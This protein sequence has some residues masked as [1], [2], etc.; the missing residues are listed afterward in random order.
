MKNRDEMNRLIRDCQKGKIDLIITKSVS[1]FARNTQE[2]LMSIRLLKELGVRVYFEEQGI[3]TDKM[4]ME[5]ILAFPGL[6]AQQES[7]SISD[8][9]RWSYKKRMKS[10]DFN[11]CKCAYGFDMKD[12]KLII[13][14]K[15][16]EVV[17]RIFTLYVNGMGKQA[18]AT[19]LNNEKVPLRYG[20]NKWHMGTIS[21]ILTNERYI[22]DALLQKKYTTDT[23][24]FKK[25][26]NKGEQ[27]Q[28]YVENSNPPII[29]KDLYYAVQELIKIK[30]FN[31]EKNK[32]YLLSGKIYF[33]ECGHSY[34]R[35]EIRG[36]IYWTCSYKSSGRTNCNNS[37]I[38]E[39]DVINAYLKMMS[40]LS[41][42]SK[43]IIDP[44]IKQLEKLQRKTSGSS[45][46]V[47]EIDERIANFS[48]RNHMLARLHTKGILKESE[49]NVQLSDINW[50]LCELRL[51]RKRLLADDK[52]D[53]LINALFKLKE[54]LESNKV[55]DEIDEL[56]FQDVVQKIEVDNERIKFIII[57]GL[58]F[59]ETAEKRCNK[60]V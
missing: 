58:E 47:H 22:G 53:A 1:R 59:T 12:G 28:Y 21:Y 45:L 30:K 6:A 56:I 35:Q 55:H 39:S 14:E 25:V 54:I 3:D 15:E 4:N 52:N 17:K 57:S 20:K 19:R 8:N 33:A 42:H 9:M 7:Q 26:L 51:Q 44:A 32:K 38:L 41:N 40:K 24:P 2:L 13:N 23:L 49:Y 10:G 34:R 16:A 48:T 60:V 5:M 11:C 29:D 50:K 31:T 43:Y 18:I 37:L 36:K 46:A 27:P